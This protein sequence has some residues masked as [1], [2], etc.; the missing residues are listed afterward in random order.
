MNAEKFFDRVAYLRKLQKQYFKTRDTK[1]LQKC[2]QVEVEIDTE[3]ERVQAIRKKAQAT[4]QP[5][6][7]NLF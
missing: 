6:Q 7:L 1:I 2:R 5:Q 4:N 3:I